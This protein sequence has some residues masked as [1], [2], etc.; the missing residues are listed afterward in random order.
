MATAP[1]EVK[2]P[3]RPRNWAKGLHS[4]LKRWA[5]LILHRR[6][7]KTTAIL[8]HHQRAALDDAWEARR[9]RHLLPKLTDD[10]L[11]ALLKRRTYWHVMPSYRQGKLTGAWDI[12]KEI[13]RPIPGVKTNEQ[14]MLVLY[15][16][17]NKIQIIG[18][19]NPDSLR[20]PGLSGLSLDE[21][22]QIP[23][24]AFG[25]VLSKSLADHVG[26]CIFSGTIKGYDQLYDT[27]KAAKGDP[28][29]F[30]LWQDVD[31]SLET[32]EGA[33]VEAL[34][35]AMEDERR[36]VL[37]GLMTQAEFDQE[38]HLSPEAAIK[39]AF[40]ADQIKAARDQKRIT[41]VPYDPALPVDTDWDLG[42]DA[43][44]VWFT[45]SERSG[46][47][48]A[49][50]YYEDVGGGLEVAIK[51]IKEKPYTYGQHWA[52]HDI[53]VREISS[54]LTRRQAAASHGIRF[55][56]TPKI[57]VADGITA[58]QLILSRCWIDEQKC[59]K[60][61]EA[62]RHYRRTFNQRMGAFTAVPVHDWASHGADAFRGLAVRHQVPREK[63]RKEAPPMPVNFA[64]S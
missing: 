32:E 47:I 21:Y 27:H 13:S 51:A 42:I 54:G 63:K 49:I 33:T 5:C 41:T 64:W 7:G 55:E 29:W 12:L 44:A 37:Q 22:S 17:G 58:V 59:E 36:L 60:G 15:P 18:A 46:A 9:L 3:Y 57:E 14:E 53:E 56:V 61:L 40:Y 39:G 52:P 48:R 16:N 11:K 20:G 50:D 35:R 24:N 4:S 19:D 43:M 10:Q 25:E 45:Q 8:N 26:Y 38:W 34:R 23:A 28:A 6:A 1:L 31:A 2:I 62:L 30:A